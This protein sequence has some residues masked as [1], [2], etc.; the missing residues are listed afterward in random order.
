MRFIY[1]FV[2]LLLLA[3]CGQEGAT[4]AAF[5]PVDPVALGAK[6]ARVCM[7]CHGPKGVSRIASYPSLA[8]KGEAYLAEQLH[9]FKHG[10]RENPMM[11]SIAI[12]L[13]EEDITHLAAYFA[14][15]SMPGVSE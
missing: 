10:T 15:Q 9:A 7:G 2:M 12:N 13:N 5:A 4:Q 6:K 11:S 8:G 1:G 14:A 3:A